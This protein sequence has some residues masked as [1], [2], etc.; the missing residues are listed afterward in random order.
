MSDRK[1]PIS[2]S[3]KR[4]RRVVRTI[5]GPMLTLVG[6]GVSRLNRAAALRE[7]ERIADARKRV[8]DILASGY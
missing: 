5:N 8:L 7:I 2:R 4:R 6:V 1:F 3:E